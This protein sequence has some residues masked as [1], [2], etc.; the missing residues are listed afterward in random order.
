[1]SVSWVSSLSGSRVRFLF[2]FSCLAGVMGSSSCV[3]VVPVV[4]TSS[5]EISRF[6]SRVSRFFFFFFTL[7]SLTGVMGSSSC[8]VE[9][10][11]CDTSKL[12]SRVSRFFFFFFFFAL[13]STGSSAGVTAEVSM[14]PCSSVARF[15]FFFFGVFSL[16]GA[17]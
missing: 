5:C 9:T 8:V 14:L 13:V 17:Q 11:P 12:C 6:C 4:E 16:H 2:F 1:M 15:F 3:R 10:S 7:V